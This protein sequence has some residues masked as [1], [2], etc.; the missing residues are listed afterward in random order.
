MVGHFF[1]AWGR[2]DIDAN[3]ISH[4]DFDLFVVQL[5]FTQ[6]LAEQLASVCVL[7]GSGFF[8]KGARR[9]QQGVEDALFGRVFG[10]V[11]NFDDFLFAQQFDG[12]VCQIANDRLYVAAHIAHFRELGGFYLDERCIGEFSQAT[13]NFGFTD[14]GRADHQDV[15]GRHFNAQLFREL[16]AAPAVTQRNGDGAFGIVLADDMAIEFVDDFAGGH[17]HSSWRSSS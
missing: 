3:G 12:S 15:L 13:C 10:T 2:G 9:W 4:F 7:R 16:H 17:G 14:T 6:A 8:A 11:A 5:A 1:H